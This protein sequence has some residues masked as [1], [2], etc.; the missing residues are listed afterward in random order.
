VTYIGTANLPSP[1]LLRPTLANRARLVEQD[2]SV[3]LPSLPSF[4]PS[5]LTSWPKIYSLLYN[6]P[7][8]DQREGKKT[9]KTLIHSTQ[10]VPVTSTFNPIINNNT[11][12][13]DQQ[14][15]SFPSFP[16][17]LGHHPVAH[18]PTQQIRI[19]SHVRHGTVRP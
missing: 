19:M 4:L 18:E 10:P 1:P 3:S 13:V 6:S 17:T 9:K 2:C 14:Q 8:P 16:G 11:Q 12:R 7:N 5:A 15:F